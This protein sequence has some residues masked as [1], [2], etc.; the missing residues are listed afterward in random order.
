MKA[1]TI[2]D[3]LDQKYGRE[4][5]SSRDDFDAKSEAYMIAELVKSARKEAKLTQE[6]LADRLQVNRAYISKIE[7][8]K[9]DVRISTLRRLVEVGLGGKLKISVDLS[10]D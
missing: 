1:K 4:G 10:R 2:N 3:H 5:T 8:A 6:E 7:R 9:S